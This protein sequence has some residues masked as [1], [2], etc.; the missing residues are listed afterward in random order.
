MT[1]GAGGRGEGRGAMHV[2]LRRSGSLV[3]LLREK[4][5]YLLRLQWLIDNYQ[6]N[7]VPSPGGARLSLG[8]HFS[9]SGFFP[10]SGPRR[11]IV[12]VTY[13]LAT[14]EHPDPPHFQS[15]SS[16]PGRMPS[17]ATSL[18]ARSCLQYILGRSVYDTQA[19]GDMFALKDLAKLRQLSLYNTKVIGDKTGL[20]HL[21]A[22]V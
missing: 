6:N 20:D 14:R 19:E 8:R 10:L 9:I 5:V 13:C 12:A 7:A 2:L 18:L 11:L 1:S 22:L 21:R 15:S 17:S 3:K 4:D 16:L